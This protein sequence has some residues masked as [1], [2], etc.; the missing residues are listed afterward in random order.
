[1]TMPMMLSPA[2]MPELTGTVTIG[3]WVGRTFL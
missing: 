3:A 2:M 1:M